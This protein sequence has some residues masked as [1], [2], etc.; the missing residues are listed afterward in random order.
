MAHTPVTPEEFKAAK[1][2]FAAVPDDVVQMCLDMAEIFVGESW[3]DKTYR[4]AIISLTCHLMTLDGQGADAE[5][6]DYAEG[7]ARYQTLRSGELTITRYRAAASGSEYT[8]WLKQTACGQMYALLLRATRGGPMVV[9]IASGCGASPY[10]KD[11]P[12]GVYGWP[13]VLV[14]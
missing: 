13:G 9:S 2:Q 1:P 6:Q 11:W 3:P 7:V 5:S 4:I 8:D 14:K 12:R 10:A